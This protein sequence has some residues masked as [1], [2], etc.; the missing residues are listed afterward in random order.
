MLNVAGSMSTNTG[1]APHSSI[2]FAVATHE[3]GATM[4]RSPGRVPRASRATRNAAVQLLT[5]TACVLP[6]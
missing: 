5:A 6:T 2:T 4:T 3:Y 1:V